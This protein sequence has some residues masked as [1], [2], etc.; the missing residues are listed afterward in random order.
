MAASEP[1]LNQKN[2]TRKHKNPHYRSILTVLSRETLC[3]EGDFGLIWRQL[4]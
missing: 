3:H 2:Q 4:P 1:Q